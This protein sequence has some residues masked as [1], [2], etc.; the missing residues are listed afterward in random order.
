[1]TN[2]NNVRFAKE[3]VHEFR[4]SVEW[5]ASKAEGLGLRFTDE[6]DITVERIILNPDLYQNV[7]EGIRKIQVNKFP[8]SL[9][10]KIEY[11]TLII[12][13]VFHNKRKP[14]EW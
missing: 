6:I 1:M 14:V 5:Y 12:L 2:V 13:R 9:F 4:D 8:Y 11:D 7:I 10:Y 3:A